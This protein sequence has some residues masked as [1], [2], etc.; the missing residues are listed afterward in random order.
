L[1]IRSR[2]G[3]VIRMVG[4]LK[5]FAGRYYLGNGT[6]RFCLL[7]EAEGRFEFA[8]TGCPGFNERS[9][10]TANVV[11][12]WLVL[13]PEK[14]HIPKGFSST[15]TEFLPVKWGS[16]T[17]LLAKDEF[18]DFCNAI[19]QRSEPR[20]E[21]DGV[22]CLREGDWTASV[23]D[24][25]ALPGE[26]QQYLL[27]KPLHAKVIEMADDRTGRLDL[28][29][30]DGVRKGMVLSAG[31]AG[32]QSYAVRVISV[33]KTSCLVREENE[34]IVPAIKKGHQIT[35]QLAPRQKEPQYPLPFRGCIAP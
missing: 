1:E 13:T 29:K 15:P 12:G 26:W 18:L 5:E 30:N 16:R 21:P 17:Y 22:F 4:K 25:P 34:L 20:T 7:V 32:P 19:N 11:K 27:R 23:L 28:G 3:A 24:Q 33:E 10:G 9:K 14:H 8:W 2:A 6:M 31:K 35:S